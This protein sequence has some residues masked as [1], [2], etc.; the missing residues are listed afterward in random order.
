MEKNISPESYLFSLVDTRG[1]GNLFERMYISECKSKYYSCL[2]SGM[3][4]ACEVGLSFPSLMGFS[5]QT[6]CWV[7]CSLCVGSQACRVT[8]THH[9]QVPAGGYVPHQPE[10]SAHPAEFCIPILSLILWDLSTHPSIKGKSLLTTSCFLPLEW[11]D[12][13]PL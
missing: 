2:L 11:G 7:P 12:W 13:H 8:L 4:G 6:V 3:I 9:G 5:G 1:T 10:C